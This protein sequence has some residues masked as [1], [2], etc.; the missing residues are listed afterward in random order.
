MKK[1]LVAVVAIAAFNLTAQAQIKVGIKAGKNISNNISND[2][3]GSALVSRSAYRG[4]HVGVVAD[5]PLTK[6]L[7][8]QPQLLYVDKGA[9]YIATSGSSAKLTMKNI[10]MPIYIMY[11]IEVPFGKLFG[12][13]G[14]VLSYGLSHNLRQDGHNNKDNSWK[15]LDVSAAAVAGVEFNG[16]FFTS[17]SYQRGLRDINKATEIYAKNQSVSLSIGYLVNWNKRKV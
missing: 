5:V 10:E 9:K 17:I 11:K 16:G 1:I 8:L 15:R 3:T 7:Y 2:G 12:G 13:A 14:P 4:Y 6:E